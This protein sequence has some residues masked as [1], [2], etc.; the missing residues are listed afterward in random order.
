V[1]K[2]SRTTMDASMRSCVE[3]R[4]L[5]FL[6]V[7]LCLGAHDRLSAEVGPTLLVPPPSSDLAVNGWTS[8]A[9][10][11]RQLVVGSAAGCQLA[12]G[13]YWQGTYTA[14]RYANIP[15]SMVAPPAPAPS[16]SD[17]SAW[18]AYLHPPT[19]FCSSMV[20][21]RWCEPVCI[22]WTPRAVHE[23]CPRPAGSVACD[24]P[25]TGRRWATRSCSLR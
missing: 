3:G 25:G 18:C 22:R 4:F 2:C 24:E 1:T 23:R 13:M 10:P 5:Q 11:Q 7:V 9:D 20:T 17:L 14:D 16:Q 19:G 6:A 8:E 15:C 12:P 21:Y